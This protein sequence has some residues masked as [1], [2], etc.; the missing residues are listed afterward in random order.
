MIQIIKILNDKDAILSG[1]EICFELGITTRTLRNELN[2]EK[3]NLKAI[4]VEIES[5]HRRGYKLKIVDEEAYYTYLSDSIKDTNLKMKSIPREP[6]ERIHYIIQRLL[7]SHDYI[8]AETIADEIYISRSTFDND[9]IKV[10]EKLEYF[11]LEIISKPA[12]GLKITGSE[13]RVRSA[14]SLYFYGANTYSEIIVERDKES[15]YN[16]ISDILLKL[17]HEHEF[18]LT[19]LGFKNLVTHIII[20]LIRMKD[21]Y[22]VPQPGNIQDLAQS[23]AYDLAN[24][25]CDQLEIKYKTKLPTSER[26]YIAMHLTGK[27]SSQHIKTNKISF[28]ENDRLFKEIFMYIEENYNMNLAHDLDLYTALS[29]HFKPMKNR[30]EYG[31]RIENPL[32]ATIKLEQNLAFEIAVGVAFIISKHW[33]FTISEEEIGYIALHIALSIENFQEQSSKKNVLI[34]CAT[35]VGS[36]QILYHKVKQQFGQSI[37]KL[38]VSELYALDTMNLDDY[39]LILSTVPIHQQVSIPMIEVNY[40]L[41]SDDVKGIS[42]L[43]KGDEDNFDFIEDYFSKDLFFTDLKGTDS[44]QIIKEMCSRIET[45]KPL[46]KSFEKSVLKREKYAS[47]EFGNQIAMP[48]PMEAITSSTFVAIGVLEKPIIWK[49][50]YVKFVLL[51]SVSKNKN[52]SLSLFH[53][54]LSALALDSKAM[55]EFSKTPTLETLKAILYSLAQDEQA[56]D[57]DRLFK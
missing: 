48:H 32:L 1:K 34:V 50:N 6:D 43:L 57:I 40:F 24:V 56:N 17:M 21:H 30:L 22:Y 16:E 53:E 44:K 38:D 29:L 4:G 55:L 37:D 11:E 12:F 28:E 15:I 52:E 20:T 13:M 26:L 31:L 35:G 19:D 45:V 10:K 18:R 7:V 9:L 47:T 27:E 36:S 42:G 25:L 2:K 51:M 23:E 54:V 5:I 41:N 46:P 49:E 3:E 14:I 8:K 33:G 39:D